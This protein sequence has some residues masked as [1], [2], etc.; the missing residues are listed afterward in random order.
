MKKNY[1]RSRRNRKNAVAGS[2]GNCET[3]QDHTG[4]KQA[5]PRGAASDDARETCGIVGV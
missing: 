3:T 4:K 1:D 2:L 5:P